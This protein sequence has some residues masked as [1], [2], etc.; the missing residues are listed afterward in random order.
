MSRA[1]WATRSPSSIPSA[2]SPTATCRRAASASPMRLRDSGVEHE[3]RVALLLNDTVDYPVAFWGAIRAGAVAI[4]LNTYLNAAAIRLHPRRLPRDGA[5]RRG[6][7]RADDLA[8][9]RA[10]AAVEHRH[11]RWRRRRHDRRSAAATCIRS[12][13]S[14]P[15]PTRRPS[16]PTPCPTKSPSGS[17]PRARPAIPR[18]SST[19]IPT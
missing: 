6:A 13:T 12:R 16:P 18:A 3:Q 8:G 1:G 14:S 19:S 10:A 15:A 11:P 9:P 5:G 4:P 2:R 17:T 7:A